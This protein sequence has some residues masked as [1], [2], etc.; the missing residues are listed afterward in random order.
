[1]TRRP[2]GSGTGVPRVRRPARTAATSAAVALVGVGLPALFLD[3]A[4]G[5][6]TTSSLSHF[7]LK[8]NEEP[9]FTV[10]GRPMTISTPAGLID[11]GSLSKRQTRT[12]VTTLHKAG[13]VKALEE[14]TKGTVNN[15]GLSLVIQF[16]SPA[17]AQAGAALL[18]HLAKS[19]QAGS[20]PFA[21]AGVT[22]AQGVT[23]TGS[24]G[25]SAN[26][27]WST[28][29]CVFG[30]GIYD[31][32]VTSAKA[33]AAPVQAAIKSQARRVGTICP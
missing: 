26:A 14:E 30:A 7:L 29:D 24:A 15:V 6:D 31:A 17:G 12:V 19:G 8:S 32:T 33:A 10:S 13:F 27:Y 20:K 2:N 25:G 5:A 11:G 3:G 1:L 16:G 23:V 21:V 22:G 4:A 9:G 28:G 18:L